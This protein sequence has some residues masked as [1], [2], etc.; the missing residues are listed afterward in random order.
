MR[1][2]EG[3]IARALA[4]APL[5]CS[6]AAA[7][8]MSGALP[9]LQAFA[10][11]VHPWVHFREVLRDVLCSVSGFGEVLREVLSQPDGIR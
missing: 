9:Y 10:D 1:L 6:P 4:F 3:A 5:R 8:V 2:F 7:A 11:A